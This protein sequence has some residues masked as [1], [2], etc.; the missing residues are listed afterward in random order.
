[1][2]S[3]DGRRSRREHGERFRR[4]SCRAARCCGCSPRCATAELDAGARFARYLDVDGDGVPYRTL[5]GDHPRAAYFT[6]GSGH[7][8]HARYTEDAAPYMEVVDRI[9]RKILGAAAVAP[10]PEVVGDDVAAPVGIVTIGG[11]RRAVLEARHRLALRGIP[12]DVLRVRAFPF[13]D[14][15]RAFID[16]HERVF[17]VEQNRDGQ[18]RTLLATETGVPIERLESLRFYGGQPLSAPPV[19]VEILERLGHGQAP[20]AAAPRT[21]EVAGS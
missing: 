3:L 9:D 11:C 2:R 7:D 18:L 19:V 15:V 14:D 6:R 16:R 20:D 17:V 5:P 8:S 10:A 21:L 13:H 4:K 12:A 1:M